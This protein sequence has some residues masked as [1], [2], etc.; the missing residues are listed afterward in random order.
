MSVAACAPRYSSL[1]ER[2]AAEGACDA[3]P[4][5]VHV[6]RQ[7]SQEIAQSIQ[8]VTRARI[9]EWIE[10]D[11]IVTTAFSPWRVRVTLNGEG[12]ITAITCG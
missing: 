12:R 6:G 4:A 7:A 1:T 3:K 10:P 9:F 8:D 11:M 5:Q 2:A